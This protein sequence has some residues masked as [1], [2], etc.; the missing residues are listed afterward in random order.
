MDLKLSVLLLTPSTT[1][2]EWKLKMISSLKRQYL[3]EV[4]IG[5]GKEY[6]ENEND[7]INDSDRAFGVICLALSPSLRYLID[8]AEYPKDLWTELDRTFGNHNEDYYS[9]LEST[10]RNTRVLYTKVSSSN[11]SNE[12]VQ[13]EKETE[14]ST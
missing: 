5:I 4:S 9:N 6:Y 10:P 8:Y 7:W 1:Y 14:S 11:L 3:Y 13:D 2:S 12:F